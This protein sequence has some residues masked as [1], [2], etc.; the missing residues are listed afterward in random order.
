LGLTVNDSPGVVARSATGA[1]LI[2]QGRS[3][4]ELKE[5][6]MIHRTVIT[7]II[8]TVLILFFMAAHPLCSGRFIF[9]SDSI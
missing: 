9:D 8:A 6:G 3:N 4:A 1:G 7:K 5:T 2:F